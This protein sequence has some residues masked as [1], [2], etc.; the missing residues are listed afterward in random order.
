MARKWCAHL[1]SKIRG[2]ENATQ[3]HWCNQC[4]EIVV[5]LI[6]VASKSA[7]KAFECLIFASKHTQFWSFLAEIPVSCHV[8]EVQRWGQIAPTMNRIIGIGH[9]QM[10]LGSISGRIE[11]GVAES[12]RC[13]QNRRRVMRWNFRWCACFS[14]STMRALQ[15][16]VSNKSNTNYDFDAAL[17]RGGVGFWQFW[18]QTV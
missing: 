4:I 15:V 6:V 2:I 18:A 12:L 3:G 14:A 1:S 7:G 8:L 10:D 5:R 17:S 11:Q 9:V 13:A 16:D